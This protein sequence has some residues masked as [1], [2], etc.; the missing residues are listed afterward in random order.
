MKRLLPLLFLLA[1]VAY[2]Q[3]TVIGGSG[4]VSGS[5]TNTLEDTITGIASG[6]ILVGDGTDSAVFVAPSGDATIT[7]G[8][9][10][11]V[12]DDSHAHTGA[13][14]TGLDAVIEVTVYGPSTSASTGDGK[15]YISIPASLNGYV[16]T[17]VAATTVTA[18]LTGSMTIQV[19]RCA[20][21]AT[22]DQC[23]GT[24]A[25]VLN[26]VVT[27]GNNVANASS[28]D[29]TANTTLTTAQQLRVDIDT[30]HS[31]TAAQGLTLFITAEAP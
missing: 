16:I 29:L 1:S 8:G 21:V 15:A 4:G 24:V 2:S 27:L 20:V 10:I 14:I 22:G 23:S 28:V 31:G 5:E 6:E 12:V 18:G 7:S 26:T 19:A 9:V 11:A 25:D 13:T 3:T 17:G 30:I